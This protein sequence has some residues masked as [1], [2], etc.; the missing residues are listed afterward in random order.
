[1]HAGK[2]KMAAQEGGEGVS[3]EVCATCP[4][5]ANLH[6]AH[7]IVVADC[8]LQGPTILTQRANV[9]AR[10]RLALAGL[11][12]DMVVERDG[13]AGPDEGACPRREDAEDIQ[14]MVATGGYDFAPIELSDD[15]EVT[16]IKA[17]QH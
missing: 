12:L 15:E 5:R 4:Y 3:H 8:R 16:I 11:T 9:E 10:Q 1:M 14:S 2:F 6:I 17:T 13:C 7:Q